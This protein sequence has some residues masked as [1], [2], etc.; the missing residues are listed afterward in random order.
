MFKIKHAL[1]FL[2]V[3]IVFCSTVFANRGQEILPERI[4]EVKI[5]ADETFRTRSEWEQIIEKITGKAF[6]EFEKQLG[7]KLEIKIVEEVTVEYDFT[8]IDRKIEEL[9]TKLILSS[10][11]LPD[12]SMLFDEETYDLLG[13]WSEYKAEEEI[14]WLKEHVN[15]EDY[16]IVVYFS[17]KD[18]ERAAGYVDDIPGRWALITYDG[19]EDRTVHILV[20][21]MGHLFGAIHY[22]DESSV[23]Y[24]K[25]YKTLKFDEI[26][27]KLILKHKFR[28]FKEQ[29][30]EN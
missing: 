23:M 13:A 16:D 28:N 6:A 22:F 18:Y 7:I 27:K 5:L 30:E 8:E 24:S 29:P 26:N 25:T 1:V 2:V 19:K 21:E 10:S 15:F 4:L 20:H 12:D 14:N 3:L 17:S 11:I 9:R